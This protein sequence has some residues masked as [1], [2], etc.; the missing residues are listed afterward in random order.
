LTDAGEAAE[1]VDRNARESRALEWSVRAGL[2]AYG[3][4]HFLIAF[5]AV[6]LAFGGGGQSATGQG[7]LAQLAA[8]AVGRTALAAMAAAFAALVVWQL[9]AAAVGYRELD[10]WQRHAMRVGALARVV[11]YGYF[12]W[13]SGKLALHGAGSSG[14]SPQSMTARVLH[15]PAGPFVLC[16]VGLV[17][18]AIGVGLAV[19]GIRKG[20]LGQL[21]EKA[22]AAQRRVPIVVV[23]QL[24]YVVKGLAFVVVGGL[25]GWAGIVRDPRKS[26]GLDQVLYELL[27][28][29]L[30]VVAVLVVGAGLA[31]FG[32]YLFARSRHLDEDSLTS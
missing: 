28:H 16:A 24:G 4:V 11:T 30:G 26:G 9:I 15:A 3:A 14:G 5:V 17:T 1:A 25:L 23:G 29:S 32:L 21:D 12:A 18:A 10:G 13:Q 20:F 27:G 19:F 8:D 22:R 2:L 31:C 6:R 7:A